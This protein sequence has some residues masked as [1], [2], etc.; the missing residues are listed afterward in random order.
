MNKNIGGVSIYGHARRN[1]SYVEN[2]NYFHLW[3]S[4]LR[5]LGGVFEPYRNLEE[6]KPH[7]GRRDVDKK[8]RS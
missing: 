1:K 6:P 5:D 8:P 2:I 3:L 7:T 4:W